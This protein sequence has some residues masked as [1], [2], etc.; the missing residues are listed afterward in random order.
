MMELQEIRRLAEA[1]WLE[2]QDGVSAGPALI[3]LRRSIDS[4]IV[5][6]LI[7]KIDD[8]VFKLQVLELA[9]AHVQH[10]TQFERDPAKLKID[11]ADTCAQARQKVA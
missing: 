2:A 3:D 1:A 9:I 6:A 10:V 8:L 4:E 7:G 5:L 11:I